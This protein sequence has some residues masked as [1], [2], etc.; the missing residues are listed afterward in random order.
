[1]KFF[2]KI[3]EGSNTFYMFNTMF[4]VG[5]NCKDRMS[6]FMR[7][8]ENLNEAEIGR[9]AA[10]ELGNIL[11]AFAETGELKDED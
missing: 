7:H 8:H 11:L 5:Q 6:F 9:G 1:M 4:Y 3:K 10:R 2:D